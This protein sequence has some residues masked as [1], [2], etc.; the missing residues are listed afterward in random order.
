MNYLTS[1][2]HQS[3]TTFLFYIST[4]AS[5]EPV[6]SV[7]AGRNVSCGG[8]MLIP[9]HKEDN[10]T[11]L[12]TAALWFRAHRWPVHTEKREMSSGAR[13]VQGQT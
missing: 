8:A 5:L 1:E 3:A 7:Q 4:T 9:S 13:G 10:P 2:E 11:F 12:L 6:I